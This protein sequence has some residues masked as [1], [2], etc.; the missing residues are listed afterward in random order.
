MAEASNRPTTR[1]PHNGWGEAMERRLT[2]VVAAD[3]VDYSRLLGE[4]E[5]QLLAILDEARTIII[6]PALAATS[7]RI[8]RLLGDG[9]LITFGSVFEA[10]TFAIALHRGMERLNARS[11]DTAPILFRIGVSLGDIVQSGGDYHGEGINIAVRLEALAPPGGICISHSVQS[12]TPSDLG[13]GFEPLGPRQLKNIAEP[14]EVW[15][16]PAGSQSHNGGTS[17]EPS[18]ARNASGQ[19]ILD[20]KVA[21]II[22]ELHMRSARLALSEAVDEILLE[23]NT[24][25][26]LQLEELYGRLGGKLNQARALLSQVNVRCADNIKEFSGGKW[27][28][29][30][31]MSEFIS[32]VFD[33]TDTSYAMK[34]LPLIKEIL[35]SSDPQLVKRLSLTKLFDGFMRAE[36]VPRML[37]LMKYAFVEL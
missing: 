12:Q 14:I 26:G 23:P 19:Q 3:I 9:T 37:L 10:M 36:M 24:G 1:G 32:G 17:A 16:W 25:S 31:P 29:N 4:N 30:M 6:D 7:G 2:A 11:P 20:P 27:P 5:E 18:Q 13:A 15:R 34:L 21:R 33:S 28:A 35:D 22:I 8:I